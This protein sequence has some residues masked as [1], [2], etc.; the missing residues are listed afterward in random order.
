MGMGDVTVNLF[1]LI[2]LFVC[3]AAAIGLW[4]WLVGTWNVN[5]WLAGALAVASVAFVVWAIRQFAER[6]V[7]REMSRSRREEEKGMGEGKKRG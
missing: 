7:K 5:P 3:A 6:M 4:G 1:V 2:V